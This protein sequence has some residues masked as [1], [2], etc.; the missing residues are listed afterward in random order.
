[1]IV[2]LVPPVAERSRAN[3]RTN[4]HYCPKPAA[5]GPEFLVVVMT[6]ARFVGR[7]PLTLPPGDSLCLGL[8]CLED[9]VSFLLDNIVVDSAPLL[10]AF[11]AGLNEDFVMTFSLGDCYRAIHQSVGKPK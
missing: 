11:G 10:P 6:D 2:A 4:R 7:V 5:S 3:N 1:M 8:K 9:A